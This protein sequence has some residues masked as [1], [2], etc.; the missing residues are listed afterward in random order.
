MLAF[1]CDEEDLLRLWLFLQEEK[2]PF[3]VLGEGTNVLV[4]DG[5][6]KGVMIK[7]SSGFTGV[8]WDKEEEGRVLVRAQAGGRLSRVLEFALQNSLTG[9]EFASGI[10]GSVGGALVMNAGA[11]GGEIKDVI[12]SI[13][14]LSPDGSVNHLSREA[15]Q[16]AYRKLDIS[17]GSVIVEALFEFE[18]GNKQKIASLIQETLNK[19]KNS[20][21]LGLPSAGSVFKN[22]QGSFAAKLIEELGFKDYQVGGAAISERHANFIV[23]RGSATAKNILELIRTIQEKVWQEKGIQLEPEIRVVGEG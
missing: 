19:R 1:P 10:P 23:N 22:P 9:L 6:F 21:P 20:Q 12:Y 11:Y 18:Q 8:V 5:G 16:F 3:F 7:L 17:P 4:R 2:I 14:V 15:L 13:R